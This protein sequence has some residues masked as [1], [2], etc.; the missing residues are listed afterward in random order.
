M[1][2]EARGAQI[3]DW[4]DYDLREERAMARANSDEPERHR[5]TL[6][7]SLS[8]WERLEQWHNKQQ[9]ANH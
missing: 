8:Q 3:D 4:A 6:T 7:L 1:H 9:H 2:R 5:I